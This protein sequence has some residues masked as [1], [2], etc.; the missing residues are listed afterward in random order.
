MHKFAKIFKRT[1]ETD[2][3]GLRLHPAFMDDYFDALPSSPDSTLRHR[4]SS[5]G[6]KVAFRIRP[7]KQHSFSSEEDDTF[8]MWKP[9]KVK[10]GDEREREREGE[11]GIEEVHG[12]HSSPVWSLTSSFQAKCEWESIS[13][14]RLTLQSV[15]AADLSKVE[16][17]CLQRVAIGLLHAMEISVS[18]ALLKG[19]FCQLSKSYLVYS[20]C[21]SLVDRI[22]ST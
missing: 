11:G 14:R 10:E 18:Y 17:E 19:C 4:A 7:A 5:M 9:S 12:V 15:N 3:G 13:G 1:K 21:V 20:F 8:F 2:N 22:P 6:G 16:M